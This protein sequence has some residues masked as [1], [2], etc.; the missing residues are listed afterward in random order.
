M[1]YTYK[2]S[3]KPLYSTV[4]MLE[5]ISSFNNHVCDPQ[6]QWEFRA[7]KCDVTIVVL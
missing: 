6:S 4:Q 2:H 1:Q 5:L 3:Q 7:L